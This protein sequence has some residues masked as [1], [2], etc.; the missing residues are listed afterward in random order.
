MH[1]VARQNWKNAEKGVS[2]LTEKEEEKQVR[3]QDAYRQ[4]VQL[5]LCATPRP[6]F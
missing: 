6:L 2:E 3:Q 4:T 5:K 1:S